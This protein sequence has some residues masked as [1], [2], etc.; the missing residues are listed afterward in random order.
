MCENLKFVKAKLGDIIFETDPV[1]I[2][3][4]GRL[5]NSC[6][7]YLIIFLLQSFL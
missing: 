1:H 7:E 4:K 6:D 5:Q 3:G 2:S